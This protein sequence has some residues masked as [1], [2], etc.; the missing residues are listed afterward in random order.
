MNEYL[1]IG[2]SIVFMTV[3]TITATLYSVGGRSNKWIRRYAAPLVLVGF[4]T[5]LAHRIGCPAWWAAGLSYPAY[6]A[7]YSLG[8]GVNSKLT[9]WLRSALLVRLVTASAYMAASVGILAGFG[10]LKPEAFFIASFL[11]PPVVYFTGKNPLPAAMEEFLVCFL[12][13]FWV[14]FTA[15]LVR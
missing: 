2:M 13:V 5:A 10:A 12:T 4:C 14:P 1:L 9:K 7:A 6:V 8:Y 15:Y 3:T 11:V